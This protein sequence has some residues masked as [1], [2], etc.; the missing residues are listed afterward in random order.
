MDIARPWRRWGFRAFAGAAALAAVAGGG[1]LLLRPVA[2]R[3]AEVVVRDLTPTVHGVGTVEAKVVVQISPQ[4]AGRLTAVLVDQ[5]HAVETGQ[6]VARLDDAQLRA[7]VHRSEAAV[8]AAEARLRDLLAGTRPEEILEGQAT[9]LRAQAQ[10]DDLLAGSRRQEI[11]ELRQRVES[12]RATRVLVERDRQRVQQLYGKEL[13]AAQE[14]DRARQA[15]EV[16]TAQERAATETLQMAIEGARSQ[17]IEAGRAQLTAAQAR[18][19]LLRAGPRPDQVVAARAQLREAQAARTLARERL[20]D[21][22]LRSPLDGVVVSRDLEPGATVNPG[23]PAL[24]VVDPRTVWVTVYVDERET[25]GLAVRDAADIALRS[26]PGRTLPGRVARIQR[27]S[28][29]VTEQLPVDV[30]FEEHPPRLT[31]G[32]QA[33]A[34]IRGAGRPGVPAVPLA[35]VVR[36]S[37]GLGAWAVVAGR[38]RFRPIR[39]G[40]T[41]AVGWAEVL[42]GLRPGDRVVVAPGGLAEPASEGRRVRVTPA[43]APA[44]GA[45]R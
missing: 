20:A 29:R 33:E 41:D 32:E 23:T 26:L 3:V 18:L 10:L 36:A 38:L 28:D 5:G 13:I 30:A 21:T 42:E 37:E 45:G 14:V 17:Q 8:H 35:A 43:A 1:W 39:V 22:V 15:S 2:V 9:A 31:L 4:I 44:G 12:A 11:E 19:A 6:I 16:A 40:V 25:H 7:E 34:T 27:E 24:K